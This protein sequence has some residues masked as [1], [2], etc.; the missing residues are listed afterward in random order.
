MA[1]DIQTTVCGIVANPVALV[2]GG[3]LL[4]LG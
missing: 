2:L 3:I 1:K 4:M